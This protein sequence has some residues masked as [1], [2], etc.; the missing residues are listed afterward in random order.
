MKKLLNILSISILITV[1][2]ST[3]TSNAKTTNDD[4]DLLLIPYNK[5]MTKLSIE[6]EVNIYVPEKNKEKFFKS[7]QDM[8]PKAFEKLLRD[9]YK[10]SEKYKKEFS[11][12]QGEYKNPYPSYIPNAEN[13]IPASPMN[14]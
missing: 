5:I 9:Q 10:E 3:T 13:T 14:P 1:L 4:I 2:C 6:Y 11:Y 12:D 7:V 8:S